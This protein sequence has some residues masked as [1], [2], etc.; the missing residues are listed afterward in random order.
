MSTFKK[1]W[2]DKEKFEFAENACCKNM[3]AHTWSASKNVNIPN[4]VFFNLFHKGGCQATVTFD[5]KMK[6][7]TNIKSKDDNIECVQNLNK[8]RTKLEEE[9]KESFQKCS[10]SLEGECPG[11]IYISDGIEERCVCQGGSWDWPGIP[12]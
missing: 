11:W 12:V 3:F 10:Y 4:K 5:I 2:F 1:I 6:K 9:M 8:L 7:I